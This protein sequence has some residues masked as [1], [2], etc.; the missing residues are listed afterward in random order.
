MSYRP[1][2]PDHRPPLVLDSVFR[3]CT[4]VLEFTALRLRALPEAKS[5]AEITGTE[6]RGHPQLLR[7]R[8]FLLA[9]VGDR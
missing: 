5:P 9:G 3:P 4:L 7:G 2:T 8:G 1:P 6:N